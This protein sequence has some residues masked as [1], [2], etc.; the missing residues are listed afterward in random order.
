MR[1]VLSTLLWA[2]CAVNG[3][4]GASAGAPP[5]QQSGG[6]NGLVGPQLVRL[7][8]HVARDASS[9]ST[10]AFTQRLL[11]QQQQQQQQQQQH[12][13]HHQGPPPRVAVIASAIADPA[14]AS[15]ITAAALRAVAK[16]IATCGMG[17]AAGKSGLLDKVALS[18]LSK[19]VFGLLQPCLLFSNVATTMSKMDATGTGPARLLPLM[20]LLQV[21]LG[22]VVGK[23]VS[24]LVYGRQQGS[25]EAKQL[26]ACTSFGN[27]GP[28]PLV[29]VDALL[30]TH[31]DA[32]LLPKS[33]AYVS[34]YLLGWSPLFWIIMPTI[35]SPARDASKPADP[36]EQLR[37]L[38]ARVLSPPV[39]GSLA[40][41][42]V[43]MV[44]FLR[45]LF[46]P[47]TGALH[48]IFGAAQTLGAGYLPAVLLVLA[49][50]MTPTA[51]TA[52]E[53]EAV[54]A[55]KAAKKSGVA[56]AAGGGDQ[57]AFIKQIV[58]IYA[59]RFVLMPAMG[60]ALV[61]AAKK[62]VP[63]LATLLTDPVLV[64]VLL[65]ETCMPSA[66]NGTVVLQ[67]LGN[68]GAAARMAR[69]LMFIYVLGIPAISYW[70]VRI[71]SM[72]GLAT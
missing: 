5:Q 4:A 62:H 35:L 67:L 50:S 13:H 61:A 24:L 58:A 11:E 46:V 51:P 65:L 34:L 48:S 20:A 9:T 16:L 53:V 52:E 18:V 56:A 38:A 55:A 26:L 3:V 14:V 29:F 69:V 45:N 31:A 47:A 43:G 22:F 54:A 39:L 7:M 2:W 23:L 59:A 49:G 8:T 60:F 6:S 17:V 19:L 71:L 28:L 40:G 44:P 30:K 33:V 57:L 10:S 70:L 1:C 42:I 32:T 72:T 21:T 66:Q 36:K 12:D 25:E 63:S 41:L 64:F 37:Q 68:R 27:A 15:K